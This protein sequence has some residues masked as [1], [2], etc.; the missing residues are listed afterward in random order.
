[1]KRAIIIIIL[2]LGNFRNGYTQTDTLKILTA[3]Y[4]ID[5][6]LPITVYCP[7][8]GAVDGL[9]IVFSHQ[10]DVST[11]DASDFQVISFD[12][13][14]Y[15]PDCALLT[16][17]GESNELS[18]VLLVGEF[19]TTQ[20]NEP[21]R[22]N[23]VSDLFTLPVNSLDFSRCLSN[24]NYN[25]YYIDSVI[26]LASGP[27]ISYASKLDLSNAQLGLPNSSGPP[28]N[29]IGG[30]CPIGTQQV[31]Q[32]AWSGG[33]TPFIN[34]MPEVDLKNY[35]TIWLDSSGFQIPYMPASI[36][37]LNDNDNYHDLCIN[38]SYTPIKVD[39]AAGFVK[40]PNGDPNS[41]TE[42]QLT[43]CDTSATVSIDE[44]DIMGN[45]I[46]YPNPFFEKIQI[47]NK[48]EIENIIL[49]SSQGEIIWAGQDIEVA[50]FAGLENGIY[51]LCVNKN[52]FKLVKTN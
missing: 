25:G 46:I 43:F 21:V 40:D 42:C 10:I 34:G 23:I 9:V 52:M 16:P 50:N 28:G 7:G 36:A 29:S 44:I 18:T 4:G 49:Y 12:S 39:F 48:H 20:I 38:A 8:A 13:T 6:Y 1:M 17:A 37:D 22:V 27:V 14:T 11:L 3:F 31:V 19:G 41:F 26:S 47:K 2:I 30:G 15:V 35:Y 32:V 45:M 33:I 51:F 5:N 24:Q